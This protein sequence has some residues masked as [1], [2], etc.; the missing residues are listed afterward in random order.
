MLKLSAPAICLAAVLAIAAPSCQAAAL[1]PALLW[2]SAPIFSLGADQQ[3]S[4]I[5]HQVFRLQPDILLELV[6][7]LTDDLKDPALGHLQVKDSGFLFGVV[8]ALAGRG[9]GS[10]EFVST[11]RFQKPDAV[12]LLIGQSKKVA[13]PAIYEFSSNSL[14]LEPS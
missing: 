5:S 13:Y 9:S 7:S 11:K 3:S 6:Y 12:V 1:S 2:S 10:E 4:R 14:R 8:D